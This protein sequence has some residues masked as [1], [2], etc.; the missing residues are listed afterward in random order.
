MRFVKT[1]ESVIFGSRWLQAPLYP[2]LIVAQGVY[3]YRFMLEPT[4]P[5]TKSG[6]LSETEIMLGGLGLI[7]DVTF[8]ASALASTDKLMNAD[9]EKVFSGTH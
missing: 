6:G 2:G 5:V 4:Q 7:D 3:G 8:P 1:M 9:P